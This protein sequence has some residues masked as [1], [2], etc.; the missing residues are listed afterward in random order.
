MRLAFWRRDN[1]DDKADKLPAYPFTQDYREE[2]AAQMRRS[3]ER[4]PYANFSGKLSCVSGVY[5]KFLPHIGTGC[6]VCLAF[7]VEKYRPVEVLVVWSWEKGLLDTEEV[8]AWREA[9]FGSAGAGIVRLED[10]RFWV[11]RELAA[12]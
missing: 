7:W 9:F 3:A 10:S 4:S 12:E 2:K 1:E 11:E 5:R 8:S 6:K